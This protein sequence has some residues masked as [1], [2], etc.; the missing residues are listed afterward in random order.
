ME[1]TPVPPPL[2]RERRAR[3]PQHRSEVPD[4]LRDEDVQAL[5]DVRRSVWRG[6]AQGSLYLGTGSLVALALAKRYRPHPPITSA[7]FIFGTLLGAAAGS[8]MG[9]TVAGKNNR[10]MLSEVLTRGATGTAY[11]QTTRDAAEDARLESHERRIAQI[12]REQARG[13]A[14]VLQQPGVVTLGSD[15]LEVHG[16]GAGHVLGHAEWLQM[17]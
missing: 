11:T 14:Q 13:H 2:P 5:N 8:F 9:A 12:K 1:S 3:R 10:W 4:T 16:V 15:G 7:H 17:Q 6:A